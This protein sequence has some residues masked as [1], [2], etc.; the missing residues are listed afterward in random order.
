[1]NSFKGILFD[2]DGTLADNY[3][4]IHLCTCATFEKFSIPVPSYEKVFTTVGGSILITMKRLLAG[5]EFEH[6]YEKV[7]DLYLQEYPNYVYCGLEP[8]PYA[9][10]LLIKLKKLNYKLA[11]FTNK[12]SEGA[13]QVLSY[14]GLD[15]YLDCI[16]STSL[17]SPRKPEKEFTEMALKAI[18]LDACEVIGIGDSPYDYQAAQCCNVASAIVATGGDS[19]DFLVQKCP[20]AL[21]VFDNL[22]YLAK[23]IFNV[24]V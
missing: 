3:T 19:K 8:M 10:A 2:L 20:N 11:C 17:H 5:S 16:I 7:A 12:Q 6:L 9:E 14:L 22:K 18:G 21:G 4:A 13:E 24:D 15:K 23:D 1:M